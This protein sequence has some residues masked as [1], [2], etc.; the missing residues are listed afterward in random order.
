MN[1]QLTQRMK[2][3]TLSLWSLSILSLSHLT[4]ALAQELP[5]KQPN[6]ITIWREQVKIGQAAQHAKHEAGFVAAFEKAKSP[7]HY[8]AMTSLTGPSEAWYVTP[9]DSHAAIGAI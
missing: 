4:V 5:K 6:L 8:L 2:R 1:T 3:I 9:F 7:Y